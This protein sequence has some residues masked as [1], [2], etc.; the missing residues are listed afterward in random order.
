MPAVGHSPLVGTHRKLLVRGQWCAGDPIVTRLG[1]GF[2]RSPDGRK[3][4]ARAEQGESLRT[5][6]QAP[7]FSWIWDG[8]Q[9]LAVSRRS[10]LFF[11][12]FTSARSN[13]RLGSSRPLLEMQGSP[14]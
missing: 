2:R 13:R 12:A 10:R 1:P 4:R 11:L 7:G 9:G 8:R 6:E 14:S 5:L 3:G